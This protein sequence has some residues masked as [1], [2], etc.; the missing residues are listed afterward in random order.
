LMCTW[1]NM[2]CLALDRGS[3]NESEQSGHSYHSNQSILSG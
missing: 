1:L 3:D 2:E